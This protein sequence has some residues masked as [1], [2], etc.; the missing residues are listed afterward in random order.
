VVN[1]KFY[2][3]QKRCVLAVEGDTRWMWMQHVGEWIFCGTHSIWMSDPDMN[4]ITPLE[5]VVITGTT[6]PKMEENRVGWRE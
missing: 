3:I 6:G 1:L 2:R 4:E 5:V